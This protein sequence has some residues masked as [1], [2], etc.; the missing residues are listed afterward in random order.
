MKIFDRSL[1]E[2]VQPI[3]AGGVRTADRRHLDELAV[4]ELD[5]VAFAEDAGLSHAVKFVRREQPSLKPSPRGGS[6][7]KAARA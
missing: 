2:H 3:D 6:C 7:R 4:D 5:T 1:E